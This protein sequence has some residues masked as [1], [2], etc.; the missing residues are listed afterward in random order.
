MKALRTR[1]FLLAATAALFALPQTASADYYVPPSNS[2]ATQYTESFPT[3]GGERDAENGNSK[4]HS[5][6]KVLG[7]RNAQRLESQGPEGDAVAEIAAETAPAETAVTTAAT[8]SSKSHAGHGA[9]K[10]QT[11][12]KARHPKSSGT[13]QQT[14]HNPQSLVAAE[15]SG[16][17]GLLEVIGQATGSSSSGGLGLLLPLVL[18]GT[19]AWAIAYVS[20][21]R[22]KKPAA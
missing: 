5:P 3:A 11:N 1:L 7:G 21:K 8:E 19:V 13:P 6:A 10:P 9:A 16:S 4:H 20:S 15:P 18:L 2:A 17:S 12:S 14:D 22:R